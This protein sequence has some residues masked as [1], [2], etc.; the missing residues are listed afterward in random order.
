MST[1]RFSLRQFMHLSLLVA[2]VFT[3]GCENKTASD[4]F[5]VENSV[6][7]ESAIEMLRSLDDRRIRNVFEN[8]DQVSYER[9]L[10]F[11]A[12]TPGG[13]ASTPYKLRTR[14][15]GENVDV[16]E[17]SGREANGLTRVGSE[18]T[19][20]F[21]EL[22]PSVAVDIVPDT[23][24]Y[25]PSRKQ[26]QYDY[27]LLP[28]TLVDGTQLKVV[29]MN[30]RA[31]MS[32]RPETTRLRFFI[33]SE[34][35]ELRGIEIETHIDGFLYGEQSRATLL[36]TEY[37]GTLLPFLMK[38]DVRLKIPFVSARHLRMVTGYSDFLRN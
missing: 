21:A 32:D 18:P 7:R 22:D 10:E 1:V 2:F 3:S 4:Q 31:D 35:Q 16:L 37:E 14:I 26:E 33:S 9:N 15:S 30:A 29:E 12:V 28:D 8:L 20:S 6:E 24:E 25:R 23:T 13:I 36:S 27:R 19:S 17:E 5:P 11:S 38:Y 34:N